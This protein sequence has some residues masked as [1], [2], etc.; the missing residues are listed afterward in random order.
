MT[1]STT[2]TAARAAFA[3]DASSSTATS[4]RALRDRGLGREPRARRR[5]R[6]LPR[7]HDRLRPRARG[8]RPGARATLLDDYRERLD[9]RIAGAGR[10]RRAARA[11]AAGPARRARA[12]RLGRRRRRRAAST[13]AGSPSWSP[14]RPSDA[15]SA[16]SATSRSP[17]ARVSFLIDC[18]GSMK[19]HIESVAMLVDVFARALDQAGVAQRGARLHDRRLERRARAA[20]LAARRP[21]RASGPAQ[22]GLPHRLQGRRRRRGAAPAPTSPRC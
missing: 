19:Q 7:L 5:R 16:S 21:A 14:R 13:A 18:S 22:R 4:Q 15:C 6:R 2:T 17:T 11:R 9:G 10:Q 12:R 8:R 20:R 1:R 3:P